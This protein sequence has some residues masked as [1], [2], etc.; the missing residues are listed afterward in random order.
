[1]TFFR[2]AAVAVLVAASALSAPAQ[3]P[4]PQL[5]TILSQ[6]DAASARFRNARAD[7]EWDYYERVVRDTSKQFGQIYFER[8]GADTDMG[9]VVVDP[10]TKAKQKVLQYSAGTLQVFDP[11]ANHIDIVHA[12]ANQAEYEGFLTLGFGG[13]GRDLAKA[14]NI[15]DGGPDTIGGVKV[16]K[17][18]LIGKD[19]S[20][21]N[22]FS[23]VTVWIDLSRGVSLKQVFNT[24]SGDIRTALY[25]NIQLNGK[26]D[27]KPFAIKTNGSTT[28]SVH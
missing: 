19:P 7:F 11:G 22:N 9:A 3:A 4:S 18:D 2:P 1:M 14:W 21:R 6:L 25:S 24:P 12:G 5:N 15:T 10:A 27:A 28:R 20:V 23:H 8:K 13:S 17:L 26:I 16:E